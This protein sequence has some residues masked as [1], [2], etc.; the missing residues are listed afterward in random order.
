[1]NKINFTIKDATNV[2]QTVTK[3]QLNAEKVL[4]Y[5]GNVYV[6]GDNIAEH[7]ARA[8]RLAIYVM[9]FL[10]KEFARH[11]DVN[12]EYLAEDVYV[13]ILTHDDEEVA[14][15]FDIRSNIKNHNSRMEEEIKSVKSWMNTLPLDSQEYVIDH[16]ASFRKR[17]TIVSKIAKVFDNIT[18][19]QLVFEQKLGIVAPD[20]AKF[21]IFYTEGK[22]VKGISKITDLLI[23]AQIKQIVDYREFAKNNDSEINFLVNQALM[24]EGCELSQENLKILIKK[25]LDIDILTHQ[26]DRN[27][28]DFSIWQYQ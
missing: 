17:D 4:R 13:T 5:I 14:E 9:P 12:L 28:I 21:A 18:G 22:D 19:S 1:M 20:Q 23:D 15:G 6:D 11:K 3:F 2:I 16:F 27:K 7:T 25:L 24:Q 10:K 26:L 8:A